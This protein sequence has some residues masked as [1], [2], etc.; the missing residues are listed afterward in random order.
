M[1]F[2]LIYSRDV[3]VSSVHSWGRRQANFVCAAFVNDKHR[4]KIRIKK[5]SAFI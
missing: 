1:M 2:L 3:V 5:C 4:S